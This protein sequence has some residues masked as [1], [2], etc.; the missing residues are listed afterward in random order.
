MARHLLCCTVAFVLTAGVS[1]ADDKDF[2]SKTGKFS[3][4]FPG[5]PKEQD[6]AAAGASGKSVTLEVN[7]N[8]YSVTY[9]DLPA[10][11]AAVL[12]M[13]ELLDQVLD[14][15]RDAAVT[16]MKGKLL[17]SSKIKLDGNAGREFKVEL[18]EKKVM[19]NRMYL[20]GT[21]VY[22]V[23]VVGSKDFVAGD[24]AAKFLKSFTL[25]K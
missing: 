17:D 12:N 24:D 23:M 9:A 3:A 5:K 13:P 15:T 19:Q 6:I 14:G 11:A 16:Q 22:Q 7:G 1:V 8:T 25:T 10:A 21:R 18:P 2:T 20:V 4:R